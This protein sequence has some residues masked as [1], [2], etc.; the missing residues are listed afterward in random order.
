MNF[1]VSVIG[2]ISRPPEV[3]RSTLIFIGLSLLNFYTLNYLWINEEIH[4]LLPIKLDQPFSR[5]SVS[6]AYSI[7]L[8]NRASR[9]YNFYD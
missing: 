6:G 9:L 5:R 2:F 3:I 7:F 8:L 4:F 1:T